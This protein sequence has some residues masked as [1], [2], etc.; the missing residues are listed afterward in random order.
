[1]SVECQP[2][3]GDTLLRLPS[4]SSRHA[5]P[6]A[7]PL[8]PNSATRRISETEPAGT[9]WR[10]GAASSGPLCRATWG[11][12]CE[13]RSWARSEGTYSSTA[14]Q[15]RGVSLACLIRAITSYLGVIFCTSVGVTTQRFPPAGSTCTASALI[16][17][18]A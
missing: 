6:T 2:K 5:M 11:V 10:A 3:V 7:Y 17:S 13:T 14:I 18:S 16:A 15:A 4:A 9:A 1:M 12:I 8:W